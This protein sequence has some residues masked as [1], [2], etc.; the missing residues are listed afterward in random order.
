VERPLG[1]TCEKSVD[2][3]QIK[4]CSNVANYPA[5]L[6]FY[7]STYKIYVVHSAK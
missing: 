6:P 4:R 5:S 2:R 3:R 7:I 1:A